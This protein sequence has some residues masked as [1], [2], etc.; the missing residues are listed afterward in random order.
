VTIRQLETYNFMSWGYYERSM[1]V[2]CSC[3]TG[4]SASHKYKLL[5]YRCWKCGRSWLAIDNRYIVLMDTKENKKI[6]H[7][8]IKGKWKFV[9][10]EVT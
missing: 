3:G 6:I 5:I 1:G 4:A 10:K 8:R 9:D 7:V 2:Y